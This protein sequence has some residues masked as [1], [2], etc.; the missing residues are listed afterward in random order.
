MS[1]RSRQNTRRSPRWLLPLAAVCL[2]AAGCEPEPAEREYHPT[3]EGILLKGEV[4]LILEWGHGA[5]IALNVTNLPDF[6]RTGECDWCCAERFSF[7]YD[8]TVLITNPFNDAGEVAL[9]VPGAEL[10]DGL[11]VGKTVVVVCTDTNRLPS[12]YTYVPG[13][14]TQDH[15][16]LEG[17]KLAI[18][19]V[20]D[21]F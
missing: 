12:F 17:R 4:A 8:N 7:E 11:T 10:M 6:G 16:S 5:S 18:R 19:E 14:S 3:T 2:L 21:V 13:A 1:E 15:W 20:L 9:D